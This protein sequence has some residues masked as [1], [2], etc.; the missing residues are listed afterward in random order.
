MVTMSGLP[1]GLVSPLFTQEMIEGSQA[2]VKQDTILRTQHRP[3]TR[4]TSMVEV[5]NGWK[6]FVE[7]SG[8]P[9]GIPVVF[10]HGGPGL[11]FE[12][13]DHQWF[14]PEKYRIVVFQQRGTW[15]C[16]PSAED[17]TTPSQ[18]FKDVTIH[19]LAKDIEA[20]RKH[21]NIDKWLVFGGSWGSTLTVYYAQE[22]AENCLGI[23]V[24][25]IFLATNNENALFL[26]GVR[27]AAQGGEDWKPEALQRLVDY[28]QSKGLEASLDDTSTIYAAYRDL[29][30]LHDDKIAQR[31][32]VTFEEYVDTYKNKESFE[33][34]MKDDLETTP[35]ERACGIWETLLM[36]GVART[37]NLLDPSRLERMKELPI[38]VVHGTKDNLCLPSIAK[39]LVDRLTSAGCAVEY[40]LVEGGTHNEYEPGM[41]DA[42]VRATDTFAEHRHF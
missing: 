28:A 5:E 39:D 30:V 1:D 3:T 38:Q 6:L 35:S 41:T 4:K 31:I 34:L 18:I 22:F 15:G 27:H 2:K 33:R 17:F 12:E 26:D 14:D 21:L 36:D 16:E 10:C 13:T 32:W 23:V 7:E 29:S 24:H 42:L 8:N 40:T 19:T 9:D 37:Y 25:G 11:K 20:I